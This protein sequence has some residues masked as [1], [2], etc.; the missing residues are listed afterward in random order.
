[1]GLPRLPQKNTVRSWKF[2]ATV[3]LGLVAL[4]L[5]PLSVA[6]VAITIDFETLPDGT[7]LPEGTIVK[8]QFYDLGVFF[9]ENES[10][11]RSDED[12]V[13]T[14]RCDETKNC[15]EAH[16]GTFA[17]TGRLETEFSRHPIVAFFET[18][19]PQVSLHVRI[20][21]GE[22]SVKLCGESATGET[23][24]CF[25]QPLTT[26]M[27]WQK[28]QVSASSPGISRIRLTGGTG[29]TGDG[30]YNNIFIDD[31]VFQREDAYEPPPIDT[32]PPDITIFSPDPGEEIT[33]TEATPTVTLEVRVREDRQLKSV[34]YRLGKGESAREA[35]LCAAGVSAC[36][37]REFFGETPISL[38][39]TEGTKTI[40][41]TACDA[42]DN[43]AEEATSVETT[44]PPVVTI[45]GITPDPPKESL[46]L[47]TDPHKEIPGTSEVTLNGTFHEDISAWLVSGCDQFPTYC[48]YMET[49]HISDRAADGSSIT[50]VLPDDLPLQLFNRRLFFAIQDHARG[51]ETYSADDWVRSAM[52]A[53]GSPLAEYPKVWGFGFENTS[54]GPSNWGPFDATYGKVAYAC[55]PFGK[56]CIPRILYTLYRPAYRIWLNKSG[57]TCVGMAATSLAIS[58]GADWKMRGVPDDLRISWFD[59]KAKFPAGIVDKGSANFSGYPRK[60]SSRWA[61]IRGAHGVQTSSEFLTHVSSGSGVAKSTNPTAVLEAVRENPRNAILCMRQGNSGHCVTPYGVEDIDETTGHILVYDNNE[62]EN[63]DPRVIIKKDTEQWKFDWLEKDDGTPWQGGSRTIYLVPIS[64][65]GSSRHA[66]ID[67]RSLRTTGKLD[68]LLA[69]VFGDA[70]PLYETTDGRRF[71][72]DRDG[73]FM[74]E[75]AEAL[76]L[77]P[78]GPPPEDNRTVPVLFPETL[79]PTTRIN[80]R[81]N[82]YTFSAMQPGRIFQLEA[83]DATEGAQD[84]VSLERDEEN[85]GV[86]M[87]RLTAEKH[88]AQLLSTVGIGYSKTEEAAFT[89]AGLELGDGTSFGLAPDEDERGVL[90]QNDIGATARYA[91]LVQGLDAD[92]E[93]PSSSAHV[94]GPIETPESADHRL[95]LADWPG[96]KR[97]RAALDRDRDGTPDET[98]ALEGKPCTSDDE[99]FNGFPDDCERLLAGAGMLALP[100]NLSDRNQTAVIATAALILSLLSLPFLYKL[101]KR[102]KRKSALPAA[103]PKE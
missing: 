65:W 36:P 90:F 74:S 103:P 52:F 102:H 4:I 45:T 57:G 87:M 14:I 83:R 3:L 28:L 71:G 98:T 9:C 72:F 41:V 17:A 39:R 7:P 55:G 86:D 38:V 62:P 91:L 78:L 69:F 10:C 46:V 58:Q 82:T 1:M 96:T 89:L 53:F 44:L 32:T 29:G 54:E 27:G 20:E 93:K 31:L 15:K 13:V 35:P 43:C 60:A 63:T 66:P 8:D 80:A 59:E 100:E 23:L 19:Q 34:T 22:G 77:P 37:A 73:T 49:V 99:N 26:S 33:I 12:G 92:G 11:D 101:Y 97:V 30:A 76:P 94:F 21:G 6:G 70:D 81:G 18:P 68:K 79:T 95:T 16:S 61:A 85:G 25:E 51:V 24:D 56:V 64:V 84:T 47:R 88:T 40:T 5:I 48:D 75:I 50:V 42:S 67:I 2:P